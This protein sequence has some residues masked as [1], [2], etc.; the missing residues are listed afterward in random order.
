MN[1]KGK[2]ICLGLA[3]LAILGLWGIVGGGNG[4]RTIQQKASKPVAAQS[5]TPEYEPPA[6]APTP[7]S[8]TAPQAPVPESQSIPV[9]VTWR[10]FSEPVEGVAIT[11]SPKNVPRNDKAPLQ[12]LTGVTDKA[13]R[14]ELA[15]PS[16]APLPKPLRCEVR[17]AGAGVAPLFIESARVCTTQTLELFL[18]KAYDFHGTVYWDPKG[19]GNIPAP[20]AQVAVTGTFIH[21][22]RPRE[23]SPFLA[24]ATTDAQGH[25][26]IRSFPESPVRL[27]ARLGEF[28]TVDAP[29]LA[30]PAHGKRSGPF[31]LYLNHGLTL[32]ALVSDKTTLQPI[33]NASVSVEFASGGLSVNGTTNAEGFCNLVGVPTGSHR[34]IAHADGYTREH[35]SVEVAQNGDNT[36]AF[37]L[38][39][40]GR[41]RIHTIHGET[42]EPIGNLEFL[43]MAPFR[44]KSDQTVQ[45][46]AQ[47]IALVDG[48]PIGTQIRVRPF[49]DK[50]ILAD[51][52][53]KTYPS[54]VVEEEKTVDVTLAVKEKRDGSTT[55][56]QDRE[57]EYV[58]ITGTVVNGTG[59]PIPNALVTATSYHDPKRA[60]LQNTFPS[61]TITDQDGHFSIEKVSVNIFPSSNDS[62]PDIDTFRTQR[63]DYMRKIDPG[64]KEFYVARDGYTT[65]D[66]SV[67]PY[68]VGPMILQV[69]AE[70]YCPVYDIPVAAGT[71]AH[72]VLPDKSTGEISGRVLEKETRVPISE[73]QIQYGYEGTHVAQKRV[74]SK[75]GSF[76]LTGLATG[77]SYDLSFEAEGFIA[78][79][80]GVITGTKNTEVLLERSSPLDGIVVEQETQKPI[81]AVEVRL[82]PGNDQN[83]KYYVEEKWD[84]TE[85]S[86]QESDTT[87][88]R[89]SFSLTPS[90]DQ[91][92]LLFLPQNRA[93]EARYILNAD[94][95]KLRDPQSGKLVIPL[96]KR[97]GSVT[98]HFA[99]GQEAAS[100]QLN[101]TGKDYRNPLVEPV[102]ENGVYRWDNLG[103]GPY[104]IVTEKRA[105]REARV[106]LIEFELTQ[107]ASKSFEIDD[108]VSASISGRILQ[109]DGGSVPNATLL[110]SRLS[111]DNEGNRIR[112]LYVCKSDANG[113][114]RLDNIVPGTYSH[115][116]DPRLEVELL[117][118][119]PQRSPEFFIMGSIEI[120]GTTQHDFTVPQ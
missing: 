19:T 88:P 35:L 29:V 98:L 109:A 22:L 90:R 97:A 69:E 103:D 18:D 79:D 70:E 117:A 74:Y 91:N 55:R 96:S 105:P 92:I 104:Q 27:Q 41:A 85:L 15:L 23:A 45:S 3:V 43:L 10:D 65:D 82:L 58:K 100:V 36:V 11:L 66:G 6:P 87:D 17:A 32:V 48:L 8:P 9:R 80:I 54:F 31:D 12:P 14:V 76:T 84:L 46:D 83:M 21:S 119:E 112:S 102:R 20:G 34:A 42:K 114:Y 53:L 77:K 60:S 1:D 37:Y 108:G 57:Q 64:K 25:Y 61:R 40:G 39:K 63:P 47:G 71:D 44:G 28:V 4:R 81:G 106:H 16:G 110:L 56:N 62:L 24:T 118:K 101:Y 89:G 26:E 51:L 111:P 94:R 107:G 52:S 49:D 67:R 50:Y 78:K 33:P 75:D 99:P 13:G 115:F 5:V 93:Y 113:Q 95:E 2:V 30:M 73:C 120:P 59:D 86:Y 7:P 68:Y 72:I 38:D 116:E